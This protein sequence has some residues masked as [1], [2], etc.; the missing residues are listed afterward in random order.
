M[1]YKKDKL[2][3]Y[4]LNQLSYATGCIAIMETELTSGT[5]IDISSI[6]HLKEFLIFTG[7]ELLKE[8]L[9]SQQ[10]VTQ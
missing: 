7:K 4:M 3:T 6:K 1:D 10:E 5:C 9:E 2:I 8:R